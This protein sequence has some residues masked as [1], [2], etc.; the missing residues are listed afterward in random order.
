[1]SGALDVAT[2]ARLNAGLDYNSRMLNSAAY[3]RR[4]GYDGGLEPAAETLAALQYAH[5]LT[6]PFENLDIH[7]GRPL[8]LELPRLFDKVVRRRRGG[9]C[10][11]LNGLLAALLR[12]LGFRVDQVSARVTT[13]GGGYGPDFDHLALI[14]HLEERWL[15]DV[16]FGDS[17]RRPLRLDERAGQ[18]VEGQEY[19]IEGDD[20]EYTLLQRDGEQWQPQFLFSTQPREL[21]EF[22]EMCLYHQTSP[23]SI[24]TRKRVCT[25]ATPGGRLTFSNG[26]LIM[27]QNGTVQERQLEGGRAEVTALQELFGV[28]LDLI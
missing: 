11:E 13:A 12:E 1:M 23:E 7:L 20:R 28:D 15:V 26:R 22:G 8:S 21:A 4:I 14:V 3:L 10:F 6:V 19:R 9:F 17:F 16:G 25:Q 5:L 27:T 18:E 24:F 2:H